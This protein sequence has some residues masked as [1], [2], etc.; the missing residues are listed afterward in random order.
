[1]PA[2]QSLQIVILDG[3]GALNNIRQRT[4]REPI[5]Q[6]QDENHKPVAGA[7]VLF[8]LRGS[9]NGAGGTFNGATEL[10]V[11]TDALGR[12]QGI[13]FTPNAITGKFSISVTAT[14]GALMAAVII[15]QENIPA[16]IDTSNASQGTSGKSNTGNPSSAAS[17]TKIPI[18]STRLGKLL[19]FGGSAAAATAVVVTLV[20]L[21]GSNAA[22]IG[23]GAGAVGH[24]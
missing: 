21:K 12:A 9:A 6:V 5:V 13:G 1:M 15:H 3:D 19:V 17:S 2:P 18:L 23:V 20:L 4:A 22:T 14:V 7:T 10:R 8:A 11:T 16:A 24:P